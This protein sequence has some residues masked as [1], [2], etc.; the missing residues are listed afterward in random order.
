LLRTIDVGPVGRGC[1]AGAGGAAG[2]VVATK[3]ID[4]KDDMVKEIVRAAAENAIGEGAGGL[5]VKGIEKVVAPG[6][7]LLR[8]ADDAIKTIEEQREIIKAGKA[9]FVDEADKK[10]LEEAVKK[11][12][13]TPGLVTDTEFLDQ[14]QNVVKSGIFGSGGLKKAEAGAETIAKSGINDFVDKFWILHINIY[15]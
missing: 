13:L 9:T 8:G 10:V 15:F 12:F 2:S 5:I 1:G 7:K 6:M 14:I 4:P 11:G 3:T